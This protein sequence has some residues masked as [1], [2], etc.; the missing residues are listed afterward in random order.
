[1]DKLQ[2]QIMELNY[3]VDRLSQI[4]ERITRQESFPEAQIQEQI[5]PTKQFNSRLNKVSSLDEIP[6]LSHN[7]SENSLQANLPL[8]IGH[9][10][11]IDDEDSISEK[12]DYSNSQV[13]HEMSCEL[14]VQRLTAQLTAAYHRIA[15]LEEQLLAKRN[16]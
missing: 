3:K 4:V 6:Q 10:D 16:H 7:V 2:R 12:S 13:R 11:I 14:Q 5:E 8:I 9:K 1:M 15:A